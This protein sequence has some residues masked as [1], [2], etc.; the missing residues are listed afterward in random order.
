MEQKESTKKLFGG[1]DTQALKKYFG[2]KI[3]ELQEE[4]RIVQKRIVCWQK[5]RILP[6]IL[7]GTQKVSE[8]K[9]FGGIDSQALMQH[10]GKKITEL[11]EEKRIVQ[12]QRDCFLAEVENIAPNSDG[13]TKN[14]RYSHLETKST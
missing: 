2:K 9:P 1:I 6:L 12:Q 14:A 4:K 13:H 7:M 11:K 10:F 5:L 3:T 8:K